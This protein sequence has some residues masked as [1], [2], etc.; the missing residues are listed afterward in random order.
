MARMREYLETQR[1]RSGKANLAR[2]HGSAPAAAARRKAIK[3]QQSLAAL[4]TA[5]WV[6][7]TFSAAALDG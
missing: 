6:Q 4:R 3:R 5:A 7:V 1:K 2:G